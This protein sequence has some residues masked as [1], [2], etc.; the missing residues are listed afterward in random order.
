MSKPSLDLSSPHQDKCSRILEAARK[1]IWHY[2]VSKTTMGE[3]AEDAQ[4]AVGT[5]YLYFKNKDEIVMALAQECRAE[6]ESLLQT[7]LQDTSMSSPEK[8]E[9]FFLE[10]FRNVQQIRNENSHRKELIAYLV[11]NFPAASVNWAERFENGIRDILQQGV[12][13]GTYQIED[14]NQ[15]A[16]VLRLATMGFFPLPYLELPRYPEERELLA[17]VQWFNQTWRKKP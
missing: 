14:V 5:I 9:A 12:E 4:M 8:L 7:I 1:R 17:V 2:G 3:I 6:Q 16:Q 10:K 11:Q 13:Q 15:S